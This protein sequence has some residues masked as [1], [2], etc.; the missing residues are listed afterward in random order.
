LVPRRTFQ[1]QCSWYRRLLAH[2]R[3]EDLW[4]IEFIQRWL[5]CHWAHPG[6]LTPIYQ[7]HWQV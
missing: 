4:L 2:I 7:H 1:I 6:V 3:I 5:Q